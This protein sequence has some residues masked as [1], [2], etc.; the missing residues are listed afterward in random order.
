MSFPSLENGP[1]SFNVNNESGEFEDNDDFCEW[2]YFNMKEVLVSFSQWSIVASGNGSTH[3]EIGEA[4]PDV[5]EDVSDVVVGS[6]WFIAENNV[7]GEQFCFDSD[8][9]THHYA[10]LYYS[11]TGDFGTNGTNTA[12][13]TATEVVDIIDG[14]FIDSSARQGIINAMVSSDGKC[15]RLWIIQKSYTGWQR[16]ASYICFEELEDTPSI[17]TSTYKRATLIAS[18]TTL[19]LANTSQRPTFGRFSGQYLYCHLKDATPSEGNYLAYCTASC[20]GMQTSNVADPVNQPRITLNMHSG[21]IIS[22]IGV[23][24]SVADHGGGLGRFQDCYFA[25]NKHEYFQT[26]DQPT[27]R[28]WIK[29]GGIIVP[30]DGS[31]PSFV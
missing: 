14:T 24:R 22:P 12:P 28:A 19:A 6:S 25:P 20:Y 2:A 29:L 18:N 4:D 11:A 1:W 7:T 23:F 31:V 15:T 17:W 10:H 30:W 5:W 8:S 3:K 21:Y 16:G 27:T 9:T 26:Y 13:P